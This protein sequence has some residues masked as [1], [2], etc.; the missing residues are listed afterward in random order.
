MNLDDIRALV[1]D[2]VSLKER[3]FAAEASAAKRPAARFAQA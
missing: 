2:S 3:F 1:A